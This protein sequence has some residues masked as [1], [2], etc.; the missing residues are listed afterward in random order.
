MDPVSK[1]QS[2]TGNSARYRGLKPF[3]PGQSGNPAGRPK[4][5]PITKIFEK[6]FRNAKNRRDIEKSILKIMLEG[7]MASVLMLREGAERIEG[8]VTEK[9]EVTGEI[10]KLSDADLA[11]KIAKLT[12]K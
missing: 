6:I 12:Q 4:K 11:E 8:K 10:N 5:A 3:K 2:D 7:K 9:L 1:A